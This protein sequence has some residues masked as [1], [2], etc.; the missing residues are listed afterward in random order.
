MPR[1]HPAPPVGVR[2][3]AVS[4][5]VSKTPSK[6]GGNQAGTH[7]R[8]RCACGS[9]FGVSVAS[10]P[11]G[12]SRQE[13]QK[14]PRVGQ[15]LERSCTVGGTVER[16]SHQGDSCGD[17]LKKIKHRITMGSGNPTSG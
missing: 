15:D 16:G 10:R 11:L 9:P 14:M 12:R 3:A 4:G 8:V 5:W 2:C 1:S 17:T 7:S 6:S 13:R